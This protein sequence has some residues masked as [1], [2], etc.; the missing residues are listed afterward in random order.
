MIFPTSAFVHSVFHPSDFSEASRNAFAHA[1]AIALIRQTKF[2]ILHV[3]D[4]RDDWTRFPAVRK[5]L[6]KWGLL[7]KE[8]PR[9]AVFEELA[10]RVNKI[11]VKGRNPVSTILSF[12]KENP[13]DLIVLS[14]KA[15]KGLIRLIRPSVAEKIAQKSKTMTLFVPADVRGFVHP[16]D[17]SFQ[18]QRILVPM[19]KTPNPRN[20][21][22]YATRI[23]KIVEQNL[24]IIFLHVSDVVDKEKAQ[25]LNAPF[26]TG[27]QIVRPGNVVEGIVEIALKH[28]TDLIIMATAGHESL[29]DILRGSTTEQVL[30]NAPCPLLAVPES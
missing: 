4:S 3:G 30:R 18:I 10:V 12:L 13:T 26:C 23:A 21:V 6:E 7:E 27:R 11:A 17:G 8:S 22:T 5:T 9:S 20:A 24:E 19:S 16:E 28:R 2:T 15:R 29:L 1:L 14:T 25:I